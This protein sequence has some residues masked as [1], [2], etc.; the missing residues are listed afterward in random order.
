M[1]SPA[2]VRRLPHPAL[3]DTL[4][5]G[6]GG[7]VRPDD[8]TGRFVLPASLSVQMLIKVEDSAVRP[9]EFV[10]GVQEAHSTIEGGCAPR[11]LQIDLSP[12]GAYQ[13]FGVPADHLTGRLVDLHDVLGADARRL[14]ERVRDLPRWTDRFDLLD[15]FFLARLRAAPAVSAEV[16][17]AWRRLTETAGTVA[18][19]EIC[20]EIGWSHKHLITRF[21]QQVGLTPK[22]AARI[23]R[24]E[25]LLSRLARERSRPDW[26][27][28]AATAGY[29]D[30]AHMIRDFRQ[31]FGTSPA[32]HLKAPQVKSVQN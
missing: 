28:L 26:D 3:R 16:R 12:L 20:R 17:F 21:R 22:R 29:A 11:Y 4:S 19:G 10:N 2:P 7:W 24:F 31:F 18:I 6:Y 25:H 23:T 27:Q 14:G 30:Q 9:P 5:K 13:V 32:A 1:T 15:R 8:R